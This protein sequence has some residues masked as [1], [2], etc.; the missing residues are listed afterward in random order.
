MT[1]ESLA[2]EAGVNKR[3][4]EYISGKMVQRAL[5]QRN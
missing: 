5:E 4:Q 2:E 3:G 1:W